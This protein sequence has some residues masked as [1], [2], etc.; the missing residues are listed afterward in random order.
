MK[1]ISNIGIINFKKMKLRR[2]RWNKE[3]NKRKFSEIAKCMSNRINKGTR[4]T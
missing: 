4:K 2:T 3:K 1:A